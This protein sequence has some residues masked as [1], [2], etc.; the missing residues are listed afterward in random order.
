MG[1]PGDGH[2]EGAS[3]QLP[4]Q[5]IEDALVSLQTGIAQVYV[6]LMTP[7]LERPGEGDDA[8]LRAPQRGRERVERAVEEDVVDEGYLH[9]SP[10][11]RSD[12]AT[13]NVLCLHHL[14]DNIEL[15]LRE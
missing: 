4:Q 14:N 15:I 11:V 10:S 5:V 12:Q 8:R 2:F 9:R 7:G 13:G 1:G 3:G 6:D